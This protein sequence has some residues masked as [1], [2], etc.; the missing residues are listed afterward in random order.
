MDDI[1]ANEILARGHL[2]RMVESLIEAGIDAVDA[3]RMG[4]LNGAREYGIAN[5]GAVAPGFIAD[6]VILPE[7]NRIQPR[8][9]FAE[10]RLVAREGRLA[11]KRDK[12]RR[13]FPLELKNSIRCRPI[14]PEVLRIGAPP[15]PANSE[16]G[17]IKTL[18]IDFP[19]PR[20]ISTAVMYQDIPVREGCLWIEEREDLCYAAVINRYGK[21]RLS[22]VPVHGSGLNKGAVAATDSHDCHNLTVFYRNPED[23]AAAV[24]ALIAC[25]G[26]WCIAAE[27]KAEYLLELPVAGLIS[28]LPIEELAP[29]AEEL[30][31]RLAERGISS[32]MR[33]AAI[34]L[35]VIP[36]VRITDKGIVQVEEQRFLSLFPDSG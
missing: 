21:K 25:G 1:P 19:D 18:V 17:Q 26:G 2:N 9:V 14:V 5:L 29:R 33:I 20:Q 22:I 31:R 11:G 15:L 35:P 12:P 27:G 30:T 28:R 6:L 36:Q 4:S 32:L 16:K 7:L 10:G 3:I 13:I 8:A 23:G 24:N 34:A